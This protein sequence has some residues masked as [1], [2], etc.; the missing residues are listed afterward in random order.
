MNYYETIPE[1]EKIKCLLCQHYCQMKEGQ[2]GVCGVN[3]NENGELK[4][5]VY[6]HP[7]TINLDPVE[8]K[9]IYHLLPGTTA[10]SFGTVG[11]NFKCPF[12]QN[13]QISQEH[14]VDTSIEVSPEKMVDLAIENG[15]SSIAYT[16]NEP[17]IFYPY[18]KDIGVIAR[19]KGLKNIFVTNGFETPEVVKDM[20]SWLDAA[21]VDLKSWDDA[22]YKKVLKGGLEAVKDTLRGMVKEGIWVEVTTL[23]I[24]GDNDSDKDLE[25]MASFIANELGIHVPW[26]L[27]AFHPDYKM[28]DHE[29]TKLQ[30][31]QRASDIAKKAGLLYV[32][33]G[34]VPVH[35]DTYCPDCGTL[36]IDRT[37]YSV[38][39]NA[40]VDGHCP[41]CNRAIEGVWK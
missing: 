41:K 36:L 4:T 9:P 11:C 8:K 14:T 35:G 29:Y 39:K 23:L 24:E 16:Y 17:T 10:L 15:A 7:S 22:Y 27:S 31:L 32:Y 26:H 19:Q 21:N 20:A 25:E 34:N 6:G 18:A 5:L 37:G 28:Q 33:M 3:K 40:L 30:T 1:K 12:C 13:W 2:V 38:T